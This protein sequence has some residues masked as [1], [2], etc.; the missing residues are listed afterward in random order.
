MTLPLTGVRV[1]NAGC[2]AAG[3]GRLPSNR[4]AARARVDRPRITT[5]D[6]MIICG[7]VS[8]SR[9]RGPGCRLGW[10]EVGRFIRLIII[11]IK[12]HHSN[13]WGYGLPGLHLPFI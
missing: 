13:G 3:A 11:R 4:T 5:R 2:R 1:G 8:P 7:E 9:L 6:N 12:L 10:E